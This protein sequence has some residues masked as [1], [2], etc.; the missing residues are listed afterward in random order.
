[1]SSTVR[2]LDV[3]TYRASHANASTGMWLEFIARYLK[4]KAN[5][6]ISILTE[7]LFVLFTGSSSNLLFSP[8]H[9]SDM[10]HIDVELESVEN[11]GQ[12][13]TFYP[14]GGKSVNLRQV[15][16]RVKIKV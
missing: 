8:I 5:I 11:T 12:I 7:I 16:V 1:M 3:M 4:S 10:S 15:R 2:Y 13:N 14:T 6:N 9:L